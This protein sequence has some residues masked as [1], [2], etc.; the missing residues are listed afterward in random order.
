MTKIEIRGRLYVNHP[1]AGWLV[2]GSWGWEPCVDPT[3]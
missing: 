1:T 2:L 3:V